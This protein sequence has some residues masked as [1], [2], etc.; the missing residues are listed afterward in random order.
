MSGPFI[1]S[2]T[3]ETEEVDVP[4]ICEGTPHQQDTVTIRKELSGAEIAQINGSMFKINSEG[5]AYA[6][7]SASDLAAME[8]AV[9]GWSF[10][11][12]TGTPIPFN[13][14]WINRMKSSAWSLVSAVVDAKVAEAKRPL[15]PQKPPTGSENTSTTEPSTPVRA[16]NSYRSS[17]STP[18]RPS[19]TAMSGASSKDPLPF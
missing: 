16:P 2:T 15:A 11:D 9:V 10:L 14:D 8:L 5:I 4:C 3:F 13:R 17:S 1:D 12:S 18:S 19:V 6:D 7:A